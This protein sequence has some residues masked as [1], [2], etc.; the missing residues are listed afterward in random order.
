MT[1]SVATGVLVNLSLT[2]VDGAGCQATAGKSVFI[3][4][5]PTVTPS[6][7]SNGTVGAAM[8]VT[9]GASGGAP[10]ST[11]SLTG[12]LPPNLQ[13][14][15]GTLSGTP[16][17]TGTYTIT[18]TAT[19]TNGCSGSRTYTF[20]IATPAGTPPANMTATAINTTQVILSWNPVASATSYDVIRT[21][22]GGAPL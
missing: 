10:P 7:I 2:T 19:D 6:S 21:P 20:A 3:N 14:S 13:F 5:G 11:F 1:Y 18:V 16:S 17:T 8:Y 12:T 4:A 15:G 9:F 22:P